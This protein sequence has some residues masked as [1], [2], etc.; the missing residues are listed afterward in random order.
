MKNR[1]WL[2]VLASMIVLL[3]VGNAGV[4]S[5][6]FS[7]VEDSTNNTLRAWISNEWVQTTQADFNAG[8]LNN[9]DT[10]ASPGDVKIATTTTTLG[11]SVNNAG[12][13]TYANDVY[14]QLNS[15]AVVPYNGEI[16]SWTYY[17]AGTT[18]NG[19]RLEFLSG[20]GTTWT[21]MA[22]SNAVTITG[23]N[24]FT[25]SIPVQAGWYLGMY[26]GSANLR[27]DSSSGTVSRRPDNSGDFGVGVTKS[28]FSQSAS[29]RHLALTAVLRY[30]LSSGT[31]A[32]QVLDTG[33][34]GAKWDTLFWSET[35][36]SNTDIT[37]EVRASDTQFTKDAATPS[38]TSVGG[39]SPVTSGLPS[40]RYM[41]WRATLT[42]SDTSKT[43]TLNEVKVYYY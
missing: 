33:I 17:N 26:T 39:T 35:L 10:T 28:D 13:L 14:I 20:S 22:K 32:S 16:V 36:Q 31:L 23:T 3:F 8:I 38:W 34:A 4:T 6:Y 42:T 12:A 43:P 21:M 41:Q 5:S 24:T 1:T 37:F 40:G 7:D 29:T 15:Y 19:A 25:V 11:N 30:Y 27:Y 18:S 9:V 2:I